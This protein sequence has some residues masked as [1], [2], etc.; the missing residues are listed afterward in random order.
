MD[1][2]ALTRWRTGIGIWPEVSLGERL[3]VLAVSVE[4]QKKR[5]PLLDDAHAGMSMS[6]NV[7][8]VS[9]GLSKPTFQIEVVLR[10]VQL[11]ASREQARRETVHQPAQM[12]TEGLGVD[13]E[14]NFQLIELRPA[15]FGRTAC[16]R[17]G[18]TDRA[19]IFGLL[20]NFLLFFGDRGQTFVNA[21]GE[22]VEVLM[23]GPFFWV[24]RLRWM[25]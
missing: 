25:D 1:C 21:L 12:L 18:R 6:V 11:I 7:P 3:R 15:L 23:R 5:G 14:L 19:D 24:S 20:A 10:Q 8:R 22:L 17:E 13:D 4:R 2:F 9:F 16:R